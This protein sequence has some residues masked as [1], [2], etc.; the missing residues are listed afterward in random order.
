MQ[1]MKSGNRASFTGNS[2]SGD[3]PA[4]SAKRR[5]TGGR[6]IVAAVGGVAACLYASM[7]SVATAANT[8]TLTASDVFGN[9]SFNSAG[10]W[11]GGNPATD[12][13]VDAF[14]VPSGGNLT[15]RSPTGGAAT[16]GG[17]SL[18]IG[19]TGTADSTVLTLKGSVG[20]SGNTGVTVTVNNLIMNGG[21]IQVSD[22]P[23]LA[24]TL[25]GNITLA[26][27]STSTFNCNSGNSGDVLI[28]SAPISSVDN[29]GNLVVTGG[30]P[31]IFTA[32]NTYTGS[33]T[34]ATG[35]LQLTT[36]GTNN[37]ANSSAIN[38]ESGS[39]FNVV[40]VGGTG[41]NAFAL[42]GTGTQSTSQILGGVGS[43]TGAV[44]VANGATLSAGTNKGTGK[45]NVVSSP[46]SSTLVPATGSADTIGKLTTGNLT[47]G[48]ASGASGNLAIK[49]SDVPSSGTPTAGTAGTNYDTI[50]AQ[51]I[52]VPSN[53]PTPPAKPFDVQLLGYGTLAS[54]VA[55][56]ASVNFNSANTY[57]WQIASYTSTNI[58]GATAST[59]QT[60]ILTSGGGLT[61]SSA[62]AGLF[63]LDTS[64]FA[65]ANNIPGSQRGAFYLEDIAAAT[66]TSGTLDVV[67]NATPEPGTTLLI[68]AGAMP[69]LSAR[70]RR[71]EASSLIP[72]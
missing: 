49:I 17:A 59:G 47:L 36:A 20:G 19:T 25:A 55:N 1:F 32:S 53:S 41:G 71:R 38:V 58:P 40:N 64:G 68:L 50:A 63:V 54:P 6:A 56:S 15:L 34:I 28:V 4:R 37:I 31:V 11:S 22:N 60:V 2:R 8:Y 42:N 14:V 16:F 62:D 5:L 52:T 26:S 9:S 45:V 12:G 39:I 66:G 3:V 43:V 21:Q 13:G 10:N 35:T 69:F 48:S 27:G 23:G 7:T 29:T 33:T 44:A 18:Q 72:V 30:A 57:V 70:R 61:A 65:T 46:A 51:T 67:Y 24:E